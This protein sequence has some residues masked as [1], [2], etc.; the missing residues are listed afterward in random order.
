M[1]QESVDDF[2]GTLLYGWYARA[3]LWM[4]PGD[5]AQSCAVCEGSA[6]ASV[7]PVDRWP[8]DLIHQLTTSLITAEAHVRISLSE[9]RSAYRTADPVTW[10]RNRPHPAARRMVVASIVARSAEVLDVL[11][12]CV[13]YRL[14]DHAML[15]LEG[16]LLELG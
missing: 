5:R 4:P 13:R 1:N 11:E 16:S 8:H 2:I 12:E 14:D 7:I 3:S 6:L 9:E 10:L 15:D